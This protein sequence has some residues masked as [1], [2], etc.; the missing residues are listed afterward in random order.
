[1]TMTKT[2]ALAALFAALSAAQDR[3]HKKEDMINIDIDP[4]TTIEPIG[5]IDDI[6]VPI[7][8]PKRAYCRM[9]YDPT[10]STTNPYGYF[11]L[12]QA[13]PWS[14]VLISGWMKQMPPAA[15]EHGFHINYKSYP[16]GDYDC[17]SSTV[18]RWDEQPAPYHTGPAG[19][20]ND[21]VSQVG[22]L[23]MIADNA[24]GNASYSVSA[25]KPTMFSWG[26]YNK[27]ILKR[28]MVIY[29][30]ED[31]FGTQPT[32]QSYYYGSNVE[33]IACCNIIPFYI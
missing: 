10:N 1:M 17:H 6:I 32:K 26:W 16:G 2:F 30:N 12:Y 33:A 24:I 5:P 25:S 28:A 7:W 20:M 27:S 31:D 13:N 19:Q 18:P 11:K 15:S 23:D 21:P 29:E 22:N 8:K 14:N 3:P 9:K 4:P